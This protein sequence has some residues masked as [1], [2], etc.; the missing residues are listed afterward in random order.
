MKEGAIAQSRA[1]DRHHLDAGDRCRAA[2]GEAGNGDQPDDAVD[3]QPSANA[4]PGLGISW[5]S[6][7]CNRA[8]DKGTAIPLAYWLG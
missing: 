4:Y 8:R 1:R 6:C 3:R 5:S 2:S 7:I